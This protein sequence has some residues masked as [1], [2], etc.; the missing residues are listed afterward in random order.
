MRTVNS[1]NSPYTTDLVTAALAKLDETA[2]AMEL[3]WG[4]DRL[5]R[6]VAADL[7][8]KFT[9]Q[10][11]AMDTAVAEKSADEAVVQIQA[12]ERGW[13]YLDK[14]AT[15]AGA[16]PLKPD[17]FEV[18]L[19]DGRIAA[20]CASDYDANAVAGRYVEVWSA[21]ELARVIEA[22]PTVSAAKQ[23][24]PGTKVE[25]VRTNGLRERMDDP[26]PF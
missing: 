22:Y 15:E 8:T 13:R 6:L 26:V 17:V 18:R 16:T 19:S 3:K 1:M 20:I 4:V 5:Q 12:L 10:L 25:A 11:D 14:V 23:T 9:R 21:D 2:R 7:T 24:F